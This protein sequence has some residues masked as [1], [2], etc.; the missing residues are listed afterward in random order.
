MKIG[1]IGLGALGSELARRFLGAHELCVWDLNAAA[2]RDFADRGARVAQSPADLARHSEVVLL[3]LPRTS[4][5]RQVLFGSG[6]LAG[7]LTPGTLVID[8]T[9]G[10]ASE[11][12]ALALELAPLGIDLMDA[13]VSASPHIVGQGGA[14]LMVGGPDALHERA[15]P[16]LRSITQTIH[17]CGLRVG[18]GQAMKTVNNAMNGACRLG[19]LEMVALG[20]KAGL[21]LAAMTDAFNQGEGRNQTTEKMLPAIAQGRASTNFALSLMLKDVN[22]AVTLGMAAGVPMPITSVTRSL[23]QVGANQLGPTAQLED[24]VGLIGA[25]AGVGLGGG[26]GEGSTAGAE[27][28]SGGA[29]GSTTAQLQLI[30]RCVAAMCAAITYECV[31]AGRRHGLGMEAMATVL[32]TTSGWST[33]S[34]RILPALS[35]G[36]RTSALSIA[37]V[38]QGLQAAARMGIEWGVPTLLVNATRALCEWGINTRGAQAGFDEMAHV[39]AAGAGIDFARA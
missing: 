25:M 27:R 1:Y 33:A 20:R 18:D 9:S 10:I 13:A 7:A 8:Q 19:T 23:L 32:H 16:V 28:V 15:L 24:M 37:E 5:V 6:G 4:D 30:D 36:T 29:A 39:V 11:T 34:Q 22:Q 12:H 3:C 31:A 21:S 38:V 35:A 26:V 2:V 14:T 17:R